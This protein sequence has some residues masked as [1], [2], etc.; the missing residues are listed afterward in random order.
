[1]GPWRLW[2]RNPGSKMII[3]SSCIFMYFYS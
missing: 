3:I 2:Y 1:L